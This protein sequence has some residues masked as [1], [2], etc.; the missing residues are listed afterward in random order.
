MDN[1]LGFVHI[2]ETG[3]QLEIL[4]MCDEGSNKT[5]DPPFF[6]WDPHAC[7]VYTSMRYRQERGNFTPSAR[8]CEVSIRSKRPFF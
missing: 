8:C 3:R 6:F 7:N 2:S 1:E 5:L 4:N